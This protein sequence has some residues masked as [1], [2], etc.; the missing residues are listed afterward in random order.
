MARVNKVVKSNLKMVIP[1]GGATPAPPVGSILGAHGLPLM[2]FINTFNSQT[3]DRK[4]EKVTVHVRVYEDKSFDFSVVGEEVSS[5]IKK[6]A[7]IQKGSPVSNKDK[8]GKLTKA[9][10]SEIAEAKLKDLNTND[11][12]SAKKMVAGSAR[13]M[14][15]EIVE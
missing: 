6:K 12:D 10:L 4:G 3:S 14:G 2:E 7:G 9:Q 8:V 5:L 1:A 15:V 11:L 13:A